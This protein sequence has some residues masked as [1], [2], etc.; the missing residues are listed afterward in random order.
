MLA[1]GGSNKNNMCL[2][3]LELSITRCRK[4]LFIYPWLCPYIYDLFSVSYDSYGEVSK[5]NE[6]VTDHLPP[7]SARLLPTQ[8]SATW[9]DSLHLLVVLLGPM[10]RS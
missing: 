6:S 3:M 2:S 1:L 7:P 8:T 9:I 4:L 5:V 10:E